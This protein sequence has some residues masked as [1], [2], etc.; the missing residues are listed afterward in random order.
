MANSAVSLPCPL[1]DLDW[2]TAPPLP[3]VVLIEIDG[4]DAYL[5]RTQSVRRRFQRLL[6]LFGE[7]AADA[8][9]ELTGSPL[10]T[11]LTLWRHGRRLWPEDYRRRLRIRPAPVLK[12]HL[13]NKFPRTSVTTRLS[14]GRALH[15]GPF[16]DR[17][18]AE[19]FEQDTLDFFGVRRCVENLEPDPAHPGC[20]WGE[21][22]KCV[23]PCQDAVSAATYRGEFGR[24]LTALESDG[25]SLRESLDEARDTASNDLEFERAA[26]LHAKSARA[27]RLFGAER[28]IARDL[29]RLHGIAVQR[30]VK[31]QDDEDDVS[32]FPL[33]RACWQS[34]IS[35]GLK[36]SDGKAVP[37][38]RRLREALEAASFGD[39]DAAERQDSIA[40]LRKWRFSSWRQGEFI[41]LESFER[42]P[43]RRLVNAVSRVAQGKTPA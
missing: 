39:G 9:Y 5:G 3:G 16:V 1:A 43:Y 21:M 18:T 14:G 27:R 32:L 10:E 33:Y 19:R 15:F 24:L 26:E 31:G 22:G 35:L 25:S 36:P 23:R 30:G 12:A 6:K 20:I 29:D 34:K 28:G 8:A 4:G 17:A 7:R 13:S 11:D 37:L 41:E 38:D 42:T 40:L 2:R